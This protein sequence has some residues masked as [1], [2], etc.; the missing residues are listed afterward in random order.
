MPRKKPTI[1]KLQRT[2][3][4]QDLKYERE[5]FFDCAVILQK[6]PKKEFFTCYELMAAFGA[7]KNAVTNAARAYD[8][9]RKMP[10]Q[11]GKG[12]SWLFNR[13]DVEDM[14]YVVRGNPP[15]KLVK[16]R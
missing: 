13:Q 14:C 15:R 11:Y 2:K 16:R 6:L 8:I 5:P 4:L 7:G 1:N 12:G 10:T 3:T 9:G